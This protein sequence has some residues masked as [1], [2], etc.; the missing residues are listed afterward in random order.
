M[1]LTLETGVSAITVFIQGLISFFSPC[2]RRL[3]PLYIG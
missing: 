2:V 3:I 1:N